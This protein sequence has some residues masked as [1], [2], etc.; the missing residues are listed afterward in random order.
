MKFSLSDTQTPLFV[1]PETAIRDVLTAVCVSVKRQFLLHLNSAF[2][3]G[4]VS[5]HITMV[6]H[7]FL[8]YSIYS[9]YIQ[10]YS[11]AI[12]P[13]I[14]AIFTQMYTVIYRTLSL[15]NM[16]KIREKRQSLVG[17]MRK[18]FHGNFLK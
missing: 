15:F 3:H 9:P 6:F 11:C 2:F 18:I 17:P 13:C 8:I 4:K 10:M 1:T 16:V 12:Y 5:Q 7:I 14:H